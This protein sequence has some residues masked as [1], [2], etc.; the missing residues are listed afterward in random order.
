MNEIKV[1]ANG[2][3]RL[4]GGGGCLKLFGRRYRYNAGR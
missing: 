3:D 4:G 1:T 2:K